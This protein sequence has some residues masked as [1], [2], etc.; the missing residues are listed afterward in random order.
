MDIIR[1]AYEKK[2]VPDV[3]ITLDQV[4]Q[5]NGRTLEDT[6]EALKA[7]GNARMPADVHAY[8]SW[9]A[10]FQ[11]EDRVEQKPKKDGGAGQKNRDKGKKKKGKKGKK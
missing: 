8:I 7:W 2:L 11:Q 3:F 6:V 10:E 1:A 4:E 5:A 9:F